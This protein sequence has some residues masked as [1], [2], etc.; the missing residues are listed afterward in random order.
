MDKPLITDWF[1]VG[2]T[3]IYAIATI[4]ITIA[5]MR[6]TNTTRRQLETSVQ[7]YEEKK[8][9]EAMPHL[10]VVIEDHNLRKNYDYSDSYQACISQSQNS[11]IKTIKSY[12]DFVISNIGWGAAKNINIFMNSNLG[13]SENSIYIGAIAPKDIKYYSW[14]FWGKIETEDSTMLEPDFIFEYFDLL[15]NKYKQIV[16]MKFE[17][18]SYSMELKDYST[19]DNELVQSVGD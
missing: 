15:G 8:R 6:S 1:M 11:R 5:N 4:A 3:V 9:L 7:Q 10:T 13:L 18:S 12:Y 2:I 16:S 14:D 19:S 17:A